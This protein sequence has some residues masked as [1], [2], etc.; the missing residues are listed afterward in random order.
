MKRARPSPWTIGLCLLVLIGAGMRFH[1]TSRFR[2]DFGFD[3]NHNW[4]YIEYLTTTWEMPDPADGWSYGHPPFF[5]YASAAVARAMDGAEKKPI[6]IA[7]RRISTGIGLLA[8]GAAVLC[9]ARLAPG[10]RRRRF[11]A[12]GVLLFLPVHLYMSAMLGEEILASSLTSFAIV[13]VA[14]LLRDPPPFRR[15]LALSAAFGVFAGLSFLTKLSG[16]L[17]MA[18]ACG[19]L[20]IAGLA[21]RRLVEG[22][23]CAVAFGAVASVIGGW[24]YARNLLEHGYLYPH[25]L[26]VHA[27]M[28]TM[29][30]GE[31]SLRDY[32]YVP[33]ATWTDPQVLHPDLIHSV[34]GST[35][36]TLWYDGHRVALPREALPIARLGTGM[37]LLALLPTCAFGVGLFRGARRAI[38]Q[39]G[40]PDTLLVLLTAATLAGYVYFTWKN[41]W[42]ATLK[43]SY[44][45]GMLVPFGV[46]TSEVLADWTRGPKLRA[47]IVWTTLAALTTLCVVVFTYHLV[48]YKFEGP[49]FKWKERYPPQ[50][51]L[52]TGDEVSQPLARRAEAEP[53]Q[54]ARGAVEQVEL[55]DALAARDARRA[56]PAAFLGAPRHVREEHELLVEAQA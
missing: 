13:G 55:D 2:I 41:P 42:Y 33:L 27:L 56:G 46:Y 1:N 7:V 44:L 51:G 50:L 43:G 24:P 38:A 23:A 54:L 15:A 31:R 49:G 48:F 26:E 37:L 25:D 34:W 22:L 21:R 4:D 30:P 6:V 28:H 32:V 19:T 47:G 29:P 39:P 36:T 12:G 9:V 35:Y 8:I 52:E 20:A 14:L 18:A 17:A 53:Q 45:L 3:A 40:G 5:Y 16:V 11:L 10:D